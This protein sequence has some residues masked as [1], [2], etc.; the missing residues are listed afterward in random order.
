[1]TTTPDFKLRLANSALWRAYKYLAPYW[2]LSAGAYLTLL[3]INLLNVAIPQFIRWII[4]RGIRQEDFSLLAWSVLSLLGLTLAKGGLAFLQ[5]WWTEI[6]SQSVAYDV[7]NAIQNQLTALS[8]SYHDRSET[9]QLLSR[10]LQDVERIRFLTGRATLRIVDGVVLLLGTAAILFWMNPRLAL[11]AV[12]ATPLLAHR[13]L[14][15]GSRFRP[16][17]ALIQDQLGILT[18]RLEQN[19]RGA[20]VVKSFAQEEAEIERFERDNRQW[21][22]LGAEAARL[23]ALHLPLMDFIGNLGTVF[24]IWY[25]GT[26]VIRG[27]LT[28]GELVA[29][30]T[31]LG[32]LVLPIRRM[33]QIIPAISMAGTAAERIFK[34]LDTVPEVKDTPQARPL[35]PVQGTVRFENVSFAYTNRH[36]ILKDISF[37]AQPGQIIALLGPTGSG[38]STITSL[39]PRFYE[40]TQGRITIDG[41]DTRQVTLTSLRSQIGIVLQETLLFAATIRENIAFGRPEASQAEI[42]AAARAAQAHEFIAKLPEGY[43]T[44]VGE[45]GVTLSGGQKQRIAI[46]RAL[47]TDPRLLILDDATASVDTETEALIQQALSHLMEGRT[48]FV[49]AHR[50]STVRRA[51]LILLLDK[52]RIV[53]RG[54]HQTLL[55]HSALYQEVYQ[56]Q[57]RPQEVAELAA[58]AA[59]QSKAGPERGQKGVDF[60]Q[61]AKGQPS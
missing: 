54:T 47:L 16:L 51:D 29:F 10:A 36:I 42:E 49:I 33:G 26:L 19:L 31:Y 28:L 18:T 55:E 56:H 8:F 60:S 24:I 57:L 41:L 13:A 30:S 21:F 5:G 37:A 1:M 61:L 48:S 22:D 53:E 35:P 25:G 7:R 9:G 59:S 17:S 50:L 12:G 38:K 46:A 58:Q 39:L 32:Q 45:R 4:D 44:S 11:L 40:P 6:A 15:F 34:I 2:R 20:R 23:Q 43:D 52:G 14:Y 3:L 27:Q